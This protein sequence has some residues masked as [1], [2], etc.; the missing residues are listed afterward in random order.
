MHSNLPD[1]FDPLQFFINAKVILIFLRKKQS[2]YVL[3]LYSQNKVST[4][5]S[6]SEVGGKEFG[7]QM[8]QVPIVHIKV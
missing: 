5:K 3:D 8:P 1:Y 4:T 6:R 7:V 2:P